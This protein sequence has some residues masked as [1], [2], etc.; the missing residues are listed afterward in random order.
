[1]HL[2]GGRD[3]CYRG[4]TYDIYDFVFGGPN[5]E[6]GTGRGGRSTWTLTGNNP[7]VPSW[8]GS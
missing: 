5:R 6:L 8:A 4:K 2:A 1:M 7:R 3:G